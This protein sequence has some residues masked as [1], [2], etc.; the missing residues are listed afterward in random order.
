[1][2]LSREVKLQ[3]VALREHTT[4]SRRQIAKDLGISEGSVRNTLKTWRET[5][6]LEG[7]QKETRGRKPV[8]TIQ[9]N[10]A[11]VRESKKDPMKTARE[12]QTAAKC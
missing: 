5:E 3:I 1:M 6:S 9:D 4:K 12:V 8:L 2:T 11:I 10:R 7:H